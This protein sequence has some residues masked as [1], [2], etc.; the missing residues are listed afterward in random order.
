M[1]CRKVG[2][3]LVKAD[4]EAQ[5]RFKENQLDPLLAQAQAVGRMAFFS[6]RLIA[7]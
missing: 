2:H 6:M 1:K 7:F 4:P 5:A 3:I